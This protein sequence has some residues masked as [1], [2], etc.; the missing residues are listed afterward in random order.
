[1]QRKNNEIQE[2][3]ENIGAIP[4]RLPVYRQINE[5]VWI[6]QL[7]EL[8]ETRS[9]QIFVWERPTYHHIPEPPYIGELFKTDVYTL[10]REGISVYRVIKRI[11][12]DGD[13]PDEELYKRKWCEVTYDDNNS[14][15]V[16]YMNVM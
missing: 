13:I 7:R 5:D 12:A 11:Y 14:P 8:I 6:G 16:V 9:G 3:M 4:L 15:N 1:M 10:E 2:A